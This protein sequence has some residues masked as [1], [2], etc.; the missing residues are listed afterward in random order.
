MRRGGPFA[1]SLFA[2]AALFALTSG[3]APSAP[4]ANAAQGATF[5][6]P[7][8]ADDFPDPFILRANGRYYAYATNGLWGDI[9][10]S[11]SKD[12]VHWSAPGNALGQL[13]NWAQLGYT[14]AP[15]VAKVG[16]QY[17]MYL[18]ARDTASGRQCV[19]AA[20][21]ARPDGPFEGA[22]AS[23]LV[24]Q[25]ALGGS[26]D[27]SPFQDRDGQRYLLWKNDG[28]CCHLPVSLWIQKLSADGLKLLGRPKAILSNT[29]PWEG[30]LIEAPTLLRRGGTYDLFY[31]AGFYADGSYA[32]G[33]ATA[34]SPLG[35]YHKGGAPILKTTGAIVGPGHQSVVT[36]GAGQSWL[37]YHAWTAGKVGY[38]QGKRSLRLDR[39]DFVNGVPT[40]RPTIAPTRAAAP[41]P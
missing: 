4:P 2:A 20:L 10:L 3:G 13:G 29:L 12:L 15:E 6:N 14:W 21:A 32:V 1:G 36:D 25:T 22:S 11:S 16:G 9:Q 33:Y 34:T 37:A 23:P 26:I 27:P 35:P 38:P 24:C 31:S 40:V 8:I 41:R 5:A 28:N 7:L 17:V 18:T 39:L 30:S 19:G